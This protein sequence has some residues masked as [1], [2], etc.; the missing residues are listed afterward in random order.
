[1]NNDLELLLQLQ[2]ID[3]DIGELERSKEYLPD[4]IENLNR[5]IG[6]TKLKLEEAKKSLEESRLKQKNLEVEIQSQ[7]ATLQ[8]YQQQMMSIKTNKEYDA[9]VAEIDSIKENLSNNET[10]LLQTIEQAEALEK[11]IGELEDKAAQVEEN[12]AKQLQILQEK[13]DSIGEIMS[14]KES[15]RGS[16]ISSIPRSTLSVYER[17]RRGKGG[18][19]VVAVKKRACGACFKALTPKKIQ[20]VKAGDR[21]HTCDHCGAIIYWDESVSD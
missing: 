11:E 3:Y 13:I 2:V 20:D 16:I 8:K 7:E 9:L 21:V 10:E 18:Q 14:N 6:E 12:N 1:M 19:A 4:M 17:V 5:E 15:D